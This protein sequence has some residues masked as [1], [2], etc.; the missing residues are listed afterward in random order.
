MPGL[1]RGG[2]IGTQPRGCP[3]PAAGTQR[4]R[5]RGRRVGGGERQC[6]AWIARGGS[7]GSGRRSSS[8]GG[9]GMLLRCRG[10]GGCWCWGDA[11]PVQGHHCH[12][13]LSKQA[14]TL[15]NASGAAKAPGAWLF[16]A[17]FCLFAKWYLK[18]ELLK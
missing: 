18:M 10:A 9:G 15:L 6:P 13:T 5:L 11:R 7:G 3:E 14:A 8:R 16:F 12:Q 17:F 2:R 1:D 4:P